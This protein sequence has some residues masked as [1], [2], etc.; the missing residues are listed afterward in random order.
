MTTASNHARA[1]G[2]LALVGLAAC[3]PQGG[4][5]QKQAAEASPPAKD[6][7]APAADNAAPAGDDGF[8]PAPP[9]GPGEPQPPPPWFSADAFEHASILKQD[10]RSNKLPTGQSA[11]MIVLELPAGTT[12]EQ[13]MDTAKAKLGETIPA[14]PETTTT[15]QGYL[16]LGGK[17][18]N[19][20][21]TIVC[22]VAKDKP[23]MFMSYIQ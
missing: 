4:G 21:F 13:C 10:E 2:L 9:E 5:E 18:P 14:L 23:T 11:T 8:T 20:E 7:E 6:R 1:L 19:Y 16:S 22:G 3:S 15:P 12:P 17:G